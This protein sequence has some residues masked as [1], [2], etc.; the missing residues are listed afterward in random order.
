MGLKRFMA[1][2][3]VAGLA[4]GLLPLMPGKFS[5]LPAAQAAS[6]QELLPNG[7]FEAVSG[8]LPD[9][10]TAITPVNYYASVT[11]NVYAGARALKLTDPSSTTGIGM[12][13]ANVP[14]G[15]GD[16]IQ[17]SVFAKDDTGHSILY[18]EFWDA[19][20]QRISYKTKKNTV[21]ADWTVLS[22]EDDA[23]EH[24]AYVTLLL[25]SDSTNTG[26]SY[27][28]VAS[29]TNVTQSTELLPNSSFEVVAGGQPAQWTAITPGSYY[30]S[31]S[32]YAY[33]GSYSLKMSDPSAGT[34]IGM[35][36]AQ[37]PIV[38]GNSLKASVRAYDASGHS[39]LYL[40]FWDASNQRI[41]YKTK[42]NTATAAWTSLNVEDVAPTNAVAATLLLYSSSSNVG[43]SYFDAASLQYA[44][45]T[46]ELLPNSGF[47]SVTSNKPALWT[48]LSSAIGIQSATDQVLQGTYSV[49]LTD[50]STTSS[51]G[52]RS[53]KVP[54][55][56]GEVYKALIDVYVSSG[57][58]FSYYIE[59]WDGANVR[60]LNKYKT[61]S[62][63][64]AWTNVAVEATAPDN[65]V[66]ASVLLYS[67][68]SNTGT[69]YFDQASLKLV[70]DIVFPLTVT[71]HPRLFFTG[72]EIPALRARS[73]DL[74]P[75][76]SGETAKALWDSVLSTAHEYLNETSYTVLY[77]NGYPVTY[78]LPPVMPPVMANPPGYTGSPTYPYWAAMAKA[79][80]Y[81]LETLSLA[82]V[83]TEDSTYAAKAKS[84][85]LSLADWE[86]WTDTNYPCGGGLSCLDT[87]HL[88]LGVSAAYD[89]LYDTLTAAEKSKVEDALER[90]GLEPLRL[91]INDVDNN[92]DALRAA[93][94]GSGGAALLGKSPKANKF[95]TRAVRYYQWYLDFRMN[96]GQTEGFNYTDYSVENMIRGIDNLTRTTGVQSYITHPFFNDFIVRWSNYFLSPG[97]G[98]LATISDSGAN[99]F[100]YGFFPNTMSIVARWLNNPY[101][102]WYL[103]Q[104]DLAGS[105]FDRFLYFIPNSNASVPNGWPSS[106]V[107]PEVGWAA[108]R[109]GW[110]G[111]DSLMTLI[112]NNNKL[113]HSHYDQNS[114]TLATNGTW[115]A[116]DPGYRDLSPGPK[117]NFTAKDGHSTIRV[118]GGSQSVK[119]GGTLQ[120]GIVSPTVDYMIGSAP[121]AYGTALTTFDRHVVRVRDYYVMMDD[122]KASSPH[123][124]DW[125]L[126]AGPV[127][128][129]KVDGAAVASGVATNGN[130]LSY[131]HSGAQVTVYALEPS[132]VPITFDKYAGAESYGYIAQV[133]GGAAAADRKFLH[134]LKTEAS[135]PAGVLAG[136][137]LLPSV[138]ASSGDII[139]SVKAAT[140]DILLYK[141]DAVGDYVDFTLNVSEPGAYSLSAYLVLAPKYGQVKAYVDGQPVGPV[142]DSYSPVT[143]S[144]PLQP[145]GNVTLTAG[146]HTVRLEVVG[147]HPSSGDYWIGIDEIRL[148]PAANN[149]VGT[150]ANLQPERVEATGVLGAKVSCTVTCSVYDYVLFKTGTSSSEYTVENITSNAKQSVVSHGA[151]GV[152]VAFA[153]TDGTGLADSGQTLLQGAANFDAS[154]AYVPETGITTGI[155]NADAGSSFSLWVPG[156]PA[157]VQVDGAAVTNYSYNATAKL[158]TLPLT[159][160]R[161]SI[162]VQE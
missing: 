11:D 139:D 67:S 43:V 130:K 84:Y 4:L 5:S 107:F 106:A 136:T 153:M 15:Q 22:V 127:K 71:G 28:D 25:Y 161:H 121:G 50:T 72:A 6:G 12:R 1:K 26:V 76:P 8:G 65:A 18:L 128:D 103:T 73:Q 156:T 9:Q 51:G 133:N 27:F 135:Q 125:M 38:D 60:I 151:S 92:A 132:V 31:D 62:A 158:L 80:Q 81:R 34:G 119:G 40:E 159:A 90:L 33:D 146:P 75:S 86:R 63:L 47:E 98:G 109:S 2:L 46:P 88:T 58:S 162:T 69:A 152:P 30:A 37:V 17:A 111:N 148:L 100:S 85:M 96:S 102:V 108:I 77:Y 53:A 141:A 48:P 105:A 44:T 93:A 79:L 104:A 41:A 115:I 155:W 154:F 45:P 29:I 122:L 157:L 143:Q 149:A 131:R 7:G 70:P 91:S 87:A 82:Y 32:S 150:D 57:T 99:A 23:P 3:L 117:Q 112:G 56:G 114:F 120:T 54:I 55:T 78:P 89:M 49:K 13:S 66:T 97:G 52:L 118:D 134:V 35:R 124:Y 126:Y 95:L 74:T 137:D 61:V 36:S 116:R 19:N 144:A 160:G 16:R 10:W 68:G 113:D 83:I 129:A 20:N 64:S 123:T 101:A 145:F 138:A 140:T 24:A 42:T 59:F 14:V 110:T 142:F 39:V 94:L 147:K 21:S